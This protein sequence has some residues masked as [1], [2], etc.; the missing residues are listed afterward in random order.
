MPTP[1]LERLTAADSRALALLEAAATPLP[2]SEAQYRSGLAGG[3]FGW[4]WVLEEP[5]GE[6]QWLAFALF[7]QVI[8]EASLLNIVTHP[9]WRRQGLARRLLAHALSA[10]D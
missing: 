1:R 3:N 6:R 4:G 8:D 7:Q 2:W 9:G 5:R 10:L